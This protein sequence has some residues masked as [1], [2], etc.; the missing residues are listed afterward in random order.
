MKSINIIIKVINYNRVNNRAVNTHIELTIDLLNTYIPAAENHEVVEHRAA[1]LLRCRSRVHL[2]RVRGA[3]DYCTRF[4][5]TQLLGSVG[6][7][8]LLARQLYISLS[9]AYLTAAWHYY[10]CLRLTGM[11]AATMFM[12]HAF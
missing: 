6:V 12:L 7:P 5:T 1:A 2:P 11:M 4:T 3:F 8:A 10:G 9:A